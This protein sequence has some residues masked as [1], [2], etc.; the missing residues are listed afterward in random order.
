MPKSIQDYKKKL[1]KEHEEKL[2]SGDPRAGELVENELITKAKEVLKNDPGMDLYDS[3]ARGSFGNNYKN[4]NLIRGPVFNEATKK[5]DFIANS[6]M[7]GLRREDFSANSN[8]I[9]N[10]AYPKSVAT[11]DSGYLGKELNATL[12]MERLDPDINSDCG[13]KFLLTVHLTKNNIHQY[14]YRYIMEN[15]KLKCLTPDI[16]KNYAGQT[17]KMRSVM[18]CKGNAKGE[19]CAKCC[20]IYYHKTNKMFIGLQ[21]GQIAGTLTNANMKKFHANLVKTAKIDPKTLLI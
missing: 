6:L 5:F 8:T 19:K 20:G 10:G 18:F 16:I 3:G 2:R 11:K 1:L 13:T 17:V 12:Q 4:I 14:D 21:T 7:D 9:V 15:G